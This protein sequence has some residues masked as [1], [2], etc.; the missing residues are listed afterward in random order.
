MASEVYGLH[1]LPHRMASPTPPATP[2][3]P[4]IQPPYPWRRNLRGEG[5]IVP[6][7]LPPLLPFPLGTRS[8]APSC[9]H[10]AVRRL[11]GLCF[12]LPPSLQAEVVGGCSKPGS[13]KKA[14]AGLRSEPNL[15]P[16]LP[17]PYYALHRHAACSDAMLAAHL[18][19]VTLSPYPSYLLPTYTHWSAR[20]L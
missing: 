7:P 11:A 17:L 1:G 13:S 10:R 14:S 3:Q 15:K 8:T 12:A 18:L 9:G 2:L 4:Q 6:L 19:Q 20:S 5:C 16:V